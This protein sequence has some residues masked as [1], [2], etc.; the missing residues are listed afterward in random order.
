MPTTISGE[1]EGQAATASNPLSVAAFATDENGVESQFLCD[2][3]YP[4][5]L[6]TIDID[7]HEIHCGDSFVAT[8]SVDLGNGAA[9]TIIITVPNEAVKRYHMT[10]DINTEVESNFDLY[11]GAT[12][13]ADGTAMTSYNRDRNS[14][15]VSSLAITH[16][17][18]TPAGGTLIYTEHWGS[19]R[20]AG[21][22]TRGQKEIVL[23]NNTKYRLV[24][25]NSTANNNYITWKFNYYIHPGI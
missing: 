16:T 25:T 12:T 11:E 1:I 6:V 7:H 15:L 17:P 21:G 24:L 8:R 2:T 9:D 3:V 20:S 14:A 19:G 4:G 18:N 22:E 10:I 5:S 13:V 23:K